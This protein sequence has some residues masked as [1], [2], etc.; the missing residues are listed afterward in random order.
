L[1]GGQER[2]EPQFVQY[3]SLRPTCDPQPGQYVCVERSAPQSEQKL[4]L[5]RSA[6]LTPQSGQWF[7]AVCTL[8]DD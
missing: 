5:S 3:W 6:S 8:D 7:I 1:S 2:V 4:G